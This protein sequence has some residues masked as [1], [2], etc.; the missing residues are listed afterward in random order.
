MFI[1]HKIIS[2]RVKAA[3]S[4]VSSSS[5]DNI[6]LTLT[7]VALVML[8]LTALVSCYLRYRAKCLHGGQVSQPLLGDARSAV[9]WEV[10]L[11]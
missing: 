10:F 5:D 9:T 11:T 8:A 4:F 1:L 3:S 6:A 2:D 7:L